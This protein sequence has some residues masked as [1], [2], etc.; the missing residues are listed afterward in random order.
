M[1]SDVTADVTSD[2]IAEVIYRNV[3]HAFNLVTDAFSNAFADSFTNPARRA[4]AGFLLAFSLILGGC[5]TSASNSALPPASNSSEQRDLFQ[6]S[7]NAQ[8]AYQESRWIDAVRS[9]QELV[10]RVPNDA[11]AWFRLANTYAQQGAYERAVYAYE[12]SLLND[13]DQ[14]KA[15]FNLSTAYLLRAQAAAEQSQARMSPD[16][17]AKA[18][19]NYRLQTINEL[20]NG[21]VDAR[22]TV[23]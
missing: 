1:T 9:Y 12:Q 20:I 16:V 17:P 4:A 18:Q 7:V 5:A 11:Q 13:N 14:P 8:R 23:R 3:N 6:L 2:V 15:W 22:K 21:P 10:E 19:L